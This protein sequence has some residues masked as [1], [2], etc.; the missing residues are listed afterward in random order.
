[1]L[2]NAGRDALH[3]QHLG[4]SQPASFQY[5]ALSANTDPSSASNTTLPGE[6]TTAG[7]GLVRGLAT[8]GHTTGANFSTLTKTFTANANDTL[9]VTVSKVGVFNASSSGTMGY[10][11]LLETTATF[12]AVGG[13]HTV[14]HTF[15]I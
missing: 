5:M 6:I 7:G 13:Q 4:D 9:P 15:T 12:S 10:E 14:T 11:T 1:M 3:N 8:H 2:T